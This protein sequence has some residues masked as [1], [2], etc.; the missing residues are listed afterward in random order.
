[1]PSNNFTRKVRLLSS[2]SFPPLMVQAMQLTSGSNLVAGAVKAQRITTLVFNA[3]RITR[4]AS[5]HNNELT[6][7]TVV[8]LGANCISG[9]LFC[10]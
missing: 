1:V 6:S 5:M 7:R 4:P 2:R 3:I 9:L 10:P 8:C